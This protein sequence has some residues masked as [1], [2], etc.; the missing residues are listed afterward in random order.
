[1]TESEKLRKWQETWQSH[2]RREGPPAYELLGGQGRAT[3]RHWRS[4]CRATAGI[5][6][7]RDARRGV[8]SPLTWRIAERAGPDTRT[9]I[10]RRGG[11]CVE[12]WNGRSHGGVETAEAGFRAARRGRRATAASSPGWRGRAGR[13][14]VGCML[15]GLSGTR[16]GARR[17]ET[18]THDLLHAI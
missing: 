10:R 13:A 4:G 2:W 14:G 7:Q 1:M 16:F 5:D 12:P 17:G 15:R 9:G 11:V 6:R 8:G 3:R 18:R